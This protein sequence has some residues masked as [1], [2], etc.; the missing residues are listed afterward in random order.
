MAFG[1]MMG[2]IIRRPLKK[3]QVIVTISSNVPFSFSNALKN[4]LP[5]CRLAKQNA[6]ALSVTL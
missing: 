3:S 1:H 5:H 4:S 6:L 2:D